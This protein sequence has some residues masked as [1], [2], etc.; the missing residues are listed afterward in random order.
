MKH[1][2]DFSKA[3][4]GALIPKDPTKIEVTISLDKDVV[5]YL[6]SLVDRAGGGSV[7]DLINDV[8]CERISSHLRKISGDESYFPK[9]ATRADVPAALKVFVRAGVGNPGRP[10]DRIIPRRPKKTSFKKAAR[11]GAK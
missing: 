1:E 6:E 4:R 9:R 3:R 7:E 5:E 10:D 2:Y 11:R 8:L